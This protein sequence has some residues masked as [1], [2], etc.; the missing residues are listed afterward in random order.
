MNPFLFSTLGEPRSKAKNRVAPTELS[1]IL[2]INMSLLR[3]LGSMYDKPLS[4]HWDKK[5]V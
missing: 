5:R 2:A 1:H 3:S 4:I